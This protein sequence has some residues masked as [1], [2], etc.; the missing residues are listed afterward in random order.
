MSRPPLSGRRAGRGGDRPSDSP[1]VSVVTVNYNGATLLPDLLRSLECQTYRHREIL[2]VDNGSTD[3]SLELLERDFP[4]VRVLPQACNRGFA[5]GNNAGIRA[6]RGPLIALVNNDTVADPCWLEELVRTAEGDPEIAAV[7]SKILFFRPFVAIVLTPQAPEADVQPW[8]WLGEE[9]AFDGCEYRKP[10]FKEG[11]GPPA[12]VDGRPVRPIVGPATLYLPV[13]P[14][15]RMACLRLVASGPAGVSRSGL[16]VALGSA[17]VGSFDLGPALAE[18]PIEIPAEQIRAESFDLINNAGTVLSRAGA[19]GDRGIYEPDRG[20]YDR[21]EDVDAFCGAAVLLRRSALDAVGLFDRDFFMYYEDTDLS[22][23]LRSRGFRLRYQPRSTIRHLHATSSVEWSP[24]FTFHVVRN[25]LLM[26]AKN[27]GP[28]ALAGAFAGELRSTA[29]LLRRAWRTRRGAP[30]VRARGELVVRLKALS[31][32]VFRLPRALLKR[33][34][35][36]AH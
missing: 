31:S 23:R 25:K 14:L 33:A 18:H 16:R 3:G 27:G 4:E 6:A 20:Q 19:A 17:D 24:L 7:C 35:A 21:A 8:A 29:A 2:V 1:L 32:L 30:G 5:G 34:G 22:W 36:L 13:G 28:R 15:D 11:F 26:I 10:V 9:S 12:S